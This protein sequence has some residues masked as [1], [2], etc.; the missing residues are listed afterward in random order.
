MSTDHILV[1]VG[2]VAIIILLSLWVKIRGLE[3]DFTDETKKMDPYSEKQEWDRY[4]Q[5]KNEVRGSGRTATES[6][7]MQKRSEMISNMKG[8]F[9]A[10][11]FF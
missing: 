8:F 2:S 5:N 1:L 11:A 3:N 6:Y 9:K 4:W 10:S 7:M